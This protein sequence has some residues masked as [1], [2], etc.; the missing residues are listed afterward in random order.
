MSCPSC[1]ETCYQGFDL[2]S[3]IGSFCHV[4]VCIC[5]FDGPHGHSLFI[6]IGRACYLAQL[7][8][9]LLPGESLFDDELVYEL[10]CFKDVPAQ[11][12][13][14]EVYDVLGFLRQ[15]SIL[16]VLGS[17]DALLLQGGKLERMQGRCDVA[18]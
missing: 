4:V 10:P 14:K 11:G 17:D 9:Y 2:Y 18:F 3:V 12:S 6:F 16:Y 15:G 8:Q 1:A 7:Q 5:Q 13:L